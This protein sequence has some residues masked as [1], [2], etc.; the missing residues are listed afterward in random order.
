MVWL[1]QDRTERADASSLGAG[2]TNKANAPGIFSNTVD[3]T[4]AATE[5]VAYY[6]SRTFPADHWAQC[7]AVVSGAAGRAIGIGVRLTTGA[8]QDGYYAGC[9][10]GNAGDSNRRIFKWVTGAWTDLGTQAV[11]IAAN[12]VLRLEIIGSRLNFYVNG[13][14]SVSVLDTT[15][16]VAGG[17]AGVLLVNSAIDVGLITEF[18]AGDFNY[19]TGGIQVSTPPNPPA[20]GTFIG[21]Y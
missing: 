8:N 10:I 1:V 18:E 5:N 3:V 9:D 7:K 14:L 13:T 6:S 11:A 19:N 17:G 16:T 12:D 15:Y 2:W 21:A 20:I 4:V